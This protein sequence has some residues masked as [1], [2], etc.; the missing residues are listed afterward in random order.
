[1]PNG[2]PRYITVNLES[3]YLI[4]TLFGFTAVNSNRILRD[5]DAEVV[6]VVAASEEDNE[7]RFGA[8]IPMY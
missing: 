7:K 8:V 3:P 4:P 6:A 1:M 5:K 2:I